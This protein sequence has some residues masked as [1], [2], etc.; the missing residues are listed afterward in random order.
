MKLPDAVFAHTNTIFQHHFCWHLA[1]SPAG[2]SIRAAVEPHLSR[3]LRPIHDTDTA[4]SGRQFL[5]FHREM[6]RIFKHICIQTN[7][8]FAPWGPRLPRWVEELFEASE[9]H[10]PQFLPAAYQRIEELI[11]SGSLDDLGNFIEA[12]SLASGQPGAGVHNA[13]HHLISA[14]EVQRFGVAAVAGAEMT[15]FLNS[16]SNEHFWGL[17]G[18]I[19][20]LY[21]RWQVAHGESPD[22]TPL[23]PAGHHH[24]GPCE[25]SPHHLEASAELDRR[26]RQPAHKANRK[27]K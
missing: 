26:I 9:E 11:V 3:D 27:Q 19:D 21:A 17:H 8:P 2:G 5:V 12:T 25:G 14:F 15:P 23:D 18:W 6:I 1:R 24:G 10:G 20:N 4:G 7:F 16:H 13:A 22:Q